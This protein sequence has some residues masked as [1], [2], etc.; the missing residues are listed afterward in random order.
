MLSILFFK[1]AGLR[2]AILALNFAA[3]LASVGVSPYWSVI[4]LVSHWLISTTNQVAPFLIPIMHILIYIKISPHMYYCN[5]WDSNPQIWQLLDC[6]SNIFA[7]WLFGTMLW[8]L[9]YDIIYDLMCFI[10]IFKNLGSTEIRSRVAG[11]RVP[12]AN[13][14]TIEPIWPQYFYV[15]INETTVMKCVYTGNVGFTSN[16]QQ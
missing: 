10:N 5:W 1:V 4:G 6:E 11:F 12:S 8:H 13:H 9:H 16:K 2:S 3:N 14:Y 7:T 15:S